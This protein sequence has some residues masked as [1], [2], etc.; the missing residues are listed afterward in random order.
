MITEPQC[1]TT[2]FLPCTQQKLGSSCTFTQSDQFSLSARRN[3]ASLTVHSAL[4]E[5]SN[6]QGDLNLHCVHISEGTFSDVAA[7]LFPG[8]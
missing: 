1:Q 6:V 2:Y 7:Q 4:T 8:F 5:G 3:F